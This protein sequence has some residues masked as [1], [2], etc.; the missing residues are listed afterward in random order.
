MNHLDSE[1]MG[2]VFCHCPPTPASTLRQYQVTTAVAPTLTTVS[3]RS[4]LRAWFIPSLIVLLALLVRW[5][6][7]GVEGVPGDLFLNG[8]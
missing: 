3:A 4:R 5:P 6:F 8:W 7:L 1:V 2:C